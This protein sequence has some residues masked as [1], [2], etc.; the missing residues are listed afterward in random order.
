MRKKLWL[1]MLNSPKI[2]KTNKLTLNPLKNG[3]KSD[4]QSH[5]HLVDVRYEFAL[6]GHVH[7]LIVGSH[8][9]LD[10]EQKNL[11]VPFLSES[12]RREN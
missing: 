7:L 11:Q 9:A 1:S 6:S 4:F 3:R 5:P 8:F 2:M 10:G 12:K